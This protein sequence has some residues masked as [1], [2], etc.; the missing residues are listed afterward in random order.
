VSLASTWGL[1]E[2]FKS[3]GKVS[4]ITTLLKCISIMI[5]FRSIMPN[6]ANTI[7]L[8]LVTA[9]AVLPLQHGANKLPMKYSW[10]YKLSLQSKNKLPPET[11]NSTQGDNFVISV[12][13]NYNW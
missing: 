11:G 13:N 4:R 5:Q 12:D 10:T 2:F 1:A 6:T 9:A 8:R 3:I 7:R